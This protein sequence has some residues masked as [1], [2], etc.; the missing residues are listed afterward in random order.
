MQTDATTGRQQRATVYNRHTTGLQPVYSRVAQT[1]QPGPKTPYN[2][3]TTGLPNNPHTP[4][5]FASLPYAD[6]DQGFEGLP[7]VAICLGLRIHGARAARIRARKKAVNDS[8]RA[9]FFAKFRP[10]QIGRLRPQPSETKTVS[11]TNE[12]QRRINLAGHPS[13]PGRRKSAISH[14][15]SDISSDIG[16]GGH[17]ATFT[18]PYLFK[19]CRQVSAGTWNNL[20]LSPAYF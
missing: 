7:G 6:C 5:V 10:G 20:G 8:S 12:G 15:L 2:R 18:I 3:S 17:G 1:I 16:P 13:A 9:D 4:T 11:V 14:R 19:A